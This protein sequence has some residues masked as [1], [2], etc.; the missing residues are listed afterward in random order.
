MS[1]TDSAG[2]YTV[3]LVLI[4]LVFVEFVLRIGIGL[5][6]GLVLGGNR[7]RLGS[8]QAAF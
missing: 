2:L 7:S 8:S 6:L 4:W 1:H 5:M 3:G